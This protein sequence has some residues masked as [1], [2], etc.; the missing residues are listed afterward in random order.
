[1]KTTWA[2]ICL[3]TESGHLG[4]FGDISLP[5]A[6]G[7]FKF[8]NVGTIPKEAPNGKYVLTTK[9]ISEDNKEV[10]CYKINFDLSC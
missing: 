10:F 8:V 6:P 1:M 3:S 7:E 4:N 5:I 2:G 9:A